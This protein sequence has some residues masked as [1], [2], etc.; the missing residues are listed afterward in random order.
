VYSPGPFRV[1]RMPC[2]RCKAKDTSEASAL[3]RSVSVVLASLTVMLNR[4]GVSG[5]GRRAGPSFKFAPG[6]VCFRTGTVV[7]LVV[8][9]VSA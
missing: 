2:L 3:F 5:L 9:V 1:T 6:S 4:M 7:A 8:T